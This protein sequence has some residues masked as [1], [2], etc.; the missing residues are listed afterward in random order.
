MPCFTSR[1]AGAI[2]AA[3]FFAGPTLASE[4]FMYD[5]DMTVTERSL[6]WIS[7]K[8]ALVFAVDGSVKVV[9][10]VVLHFE[11][12]PIEG[13]VLRNNASRAI[14]KWTV[15]GARADNGTSFANF[16]YRASIAKKTGKME[17]SA[18]PREYDLGLRSAGTC[19]K[20]VP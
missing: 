1:V 20:R 6:G 11:G 10:A 2:V 16:D 5:C 15:K 4:A 12:G 14:V 9:D 13:T 7:P 8:I 18:I 3:V 19:N 17:L